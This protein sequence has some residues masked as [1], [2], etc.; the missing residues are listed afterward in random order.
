MLLITVNSRAFGRE[1]FAVGAPYEVLGYWLTSDVGHA[2]GEE[3]LQ[4]VRQVLS[5]AK[6]SAEGTGNAFA[7][8]VGPE[9]SR[10]ECEYDEG[11]VLDLPT[12]LVLEGLER[13]IEFRRSR[14]KG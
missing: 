14:E 2:G 8:Y 12:S 10:I 1:A 5:G 6:H 3:W 11:Q 13:F 4:L 7:I 9:W